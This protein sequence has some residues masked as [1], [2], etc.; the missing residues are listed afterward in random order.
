MTVKY[1]TVP[2]AFEEIFA[3]G[4]RFVKG[5]FDRK[6]EDAAQG[7]IA[8]GGE[9]YILVRAAALSSSFLR[10]L[11]DVYPELNNPDG[12]RVATKILYDVAHALGKADAEAFHRAT[13]VREPLDKL[14]TGPVHFAFAGW[15]SVDI[16]PESQPIPDEN[17]Y[18]AYDHPRSFEADS[19]RREGWNTE[20]C[21][22]FM[23]A[24]YSSGWC[25]ESFSLNLA[26][27]EILCRAKGDS[28][29]RF[30]MAPPDRLD[31]RIDAYVKGNPALFK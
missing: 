24:G 4:E 3:R 23:N 11:G 5:Y 17:F 7:T 15:A 1:V 19:W 6:V 26:A 18:L 27:R 22:C 29:C 31:T 12:I 2:E 21:A 13:G 25:A 8:I 30:I 20:F 9:R 16:L 10:I 14:S 28:N